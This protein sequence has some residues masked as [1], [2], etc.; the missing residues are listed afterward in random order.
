V[1]RASWDGLPPASLVAAALF[2]R[3]RSEEE[4]RGE[5]IK[6]TVLQRETN[7]TRPATN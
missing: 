3:A 5:Q 2:A 1:L 6:E 4:A 7:L